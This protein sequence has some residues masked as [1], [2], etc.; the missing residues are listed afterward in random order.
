MTRAFHRRPRAADHRRT[1]GGAVRDGIF[2]AGRVVEIAAHA[3]AATRM[4]APPPCR[5][6]LPAAERG[7]DHRVSDVAGESCWTQ[8][9]VTLPA[10][11]GVTGVTSRRVAWL[12]A[13]GALAVRMAVVL[14]SRRYQATGDGSDYMRLS[15]ALLAGQGMPSAFRDGP[16]AFRPPGYPLLAAAALAVHDSVT[17]LRLLNAAIGTL[18]VVLVGAMAAE[19]ARRCG[20]DPAAPRLVA[21]VLAGFAPPFVLMD[22]TPMSEP[23][24]SALLVG[25]LLT[26]LKACRSGR[27][28]PAAAAGVIGGAAV[29]VRP[30]GAVVLVAITVVVW[31][32]RHGQLVGS[33]RAGLV[34]LAV[35]AALVLPYTA[36]NAAR[37]HAFLPV[38]DAS[39]V[40]L[41][42]AYNDVARLSPDHPG[43]WIVPFAVPALEPVL[44]DRRL[45]ERQMSSQMLAIV[46]RYARSHPA[47]A[48]SVPLRNLVRMV[49]GDRADT[50][51]DVAGLGLGPTAAGLWRWGGGLLLALGGLG[52][53]VHRP[54]AP[55]SR[56]GALASCWPSPPASREA[57]CATS[58]PPSC[59]WSPR[60]RPVSRSWW[61]G[62]GAAG[63]TALGLP[64]RGRRG[65]GPCSGAAK[66]GTCCD[67]VRGDGERG[68]S[69]CG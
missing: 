69:R 44:A 24:A 17:T 53:I 2:Q 20:R 62:D 9:L 65:R 33:A 36:R 45:D 3:A 15:R 25:G 55:R 35:G 14:S 5:D 46:K 47:Y 21:L 67:R 18:T 59:S 40:T 32:P 27:L 66:R 29:V 19:V 56:C 41:A 68:E 42:G 6:P 38:T 11:A 43:R 54:R 28:L 49:A 13:A 39:G 50:V 8:A 48:A 10:A 7:G 1:H 52:L 57:R 22:T 4:V 23:L 60:R 16:S 26:A 61:A 51:H 34:T 12:L 63:R 37:F 58:C 64:V 31:S 30:A